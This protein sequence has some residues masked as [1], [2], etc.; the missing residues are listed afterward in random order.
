MAK[1]TLD[2]SING[3][4]YNGIL[5]NG[6]YYNGV[7]VWSHNIV[8]HTITF[9]PG[10]GYVVTNDGSIEYSPIEITTINRKLPY[11]PYTAYLDGHTFLGWFN[12]QGEE[13]DIDSSTVFTED[14]V[15]YAHYVNVD[16]GFP[17]DLP[18]YGQD[19]SWSHEEGMDWASNAGLDV[20]SLRLYFII[21]GVSWSGD[22][23]WPYQ[24]ANYRQTWREWCNEHYQIGNL[25]YDEE[26][27]VVVE[28][29]FTGVYIIVDGVLARTLSVDPDEEIGWFVY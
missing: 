2:S 22:P 21:D 13:V 19:E 5:V 23:K 17:T 29:N 18:M 24:E 11:Y 28:C 15:V 9:D 27:N 10:A 7:L 6:V 20:D 1:I 26:A 14:I 3:V 4:Y 8:E 16:D 12:E 25:W